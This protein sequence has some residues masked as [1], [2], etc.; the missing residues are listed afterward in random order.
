[1]L[2]ILSNKIA[3]MNKAAE[4]IGDRIKRAREEAELTQQQLGDLVGISASA[5][6]QLE[7]GS[8]KSPNPTNLFKAARALKK[9]PE[10]LITGEGE[11]SP[12]DDIREAIGALPDDNPQLVLDFIQYR[13]EKAAGLIAG[14]RATEY[15]AMIENFKQDLEARK[16]KS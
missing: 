8:S 15:I 14:E 13:W 7:G 5:I 4:T 11:E 2:N 9:N 10:W 6:S 12:V 3:Y 1:M 16:K